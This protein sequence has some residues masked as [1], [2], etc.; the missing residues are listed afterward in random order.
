M[1]CRRVRACVF[2]DRSHSHFLPPGRIYFKDVVGTFSVVCVTAQL[3]VRQDD[4]PV[5]PGELTCG[6]DTDMNVI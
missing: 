1:D 4:V 6:R 5:V 3:S 2:D